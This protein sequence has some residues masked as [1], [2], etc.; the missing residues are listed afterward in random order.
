MSW[1]WEAKRS[2]AEKLHIMGSDLSLSH[3]GLAVGAVAAVEQ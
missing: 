3:M 1:T 2:M